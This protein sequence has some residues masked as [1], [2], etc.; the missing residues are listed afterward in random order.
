MCGKCVN[1]MSDKSNSAGRARP[2][3]ST[4]ITWASRAR[5]AY[6]ISWTCLTLAQF[7]VVSSSQAQVRLSS[8]ALKRTMHRHVIVAA[9][10]T[11][12]MASGQ[13]APEGD[14]PGSEVGFLFSV[15]MLSCPLSVQ[16]SG[17]VPEQH[18]HGWWKLFL[19]ELVRSLQFNLQ[20]K[21]F[22][23]KYPSVLEV[24]LNTPAHLGV[25]MELGLPV[26]VV[27]G[28]ELAPGHTLKKAVVAMLQGTSGTL[29]IFM[30]NTQLT[31]FH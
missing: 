23:A 2:A 9:S 12:A 16:K 5:P 3:Y 7:V 19:T 4:T 6:Q 28:F 31:P 20:L 27:S 11:L 26:S 25:Y 21:G 17:Q 18:I 10:R 14:L 1:C 13:V 8:S 30:S 24:G 29:C 15:S 22:S